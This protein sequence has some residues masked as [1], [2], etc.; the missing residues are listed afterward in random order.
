MAK[1]QWSVIETKLHINCMKLLAVLRAFQAMSLRGKAVIAAK[2]N[3]VTAATIS[4][5]GPRS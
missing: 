5:Q 1:G 2:D 4:K 3:S